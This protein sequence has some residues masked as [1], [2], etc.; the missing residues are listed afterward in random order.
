MAEMGREKSVRVILLR[1]VQPLVDNVTW[2]AEWVCTRL[3]A[4]E[5]LACRSLLNQPRVSLRSSCRF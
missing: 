5:T 1:T 3:T 4:I 2:M